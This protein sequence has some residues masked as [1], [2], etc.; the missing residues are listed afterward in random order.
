[1]L[2]KHSRMTTQPRRKTPQRTKVFSDQKPRP[3]MVTFKRKEDI[4]LV[5]R[6]LKFL[7]KTKENL[8][9]HNRI[10]RYDSLQ[11]RRGRIT[12]SQIKKKLEYEEKGIAP[13]YSER[14]TVNK[15]KK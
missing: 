9:G 1:M 4:E 5:T 12:G 14:D 2:I 7:V 13:T 11:K 6:N 3:L 15:S 10:T 8:K